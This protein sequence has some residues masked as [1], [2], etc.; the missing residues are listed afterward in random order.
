M[1]K[2][3]RRVFVNLAVA[4]VATVTLFTMSP[5]AGQAPT[6][7]Q[8]PRAPDGKPD[9]TGFWQ[10]VNTANWDLE[11]QAGGPAPK[12]GLMLGAVGAIPP[13]LGVV[14]GGKIPYQPWA[15][16]QREENRKNWPALDPEVKCFLPGVPRVTYLPYPFQILQNKDRILMIYQYS[17]A[18]RDIHMTTHEEAP[19]DQLLGWSNGRW[20]GDTLVI[21]VTGFAEPPGVRPDR[22]AIGNWLDRTG[23]FHSPGLHVVERYVPLGPAHLMYE[24]TLED[25]KVYTRP[26]KISMPLYRRL[27]KNMQILEFKCAE[28]VEEM[29]WGQW[30][31]PPPAK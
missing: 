8:V 24:V 19:I 29:N 3:T 5:V 31:K 30:R 17:Y 21:D 27:E 4:A 26:W 13:G 28:Y 18:R 7:G 2:Q 20:E 1:R 16:A 10:A 22:P 12:E 15:L 11:A 14:D 25:P 9:L 6:A 23:N